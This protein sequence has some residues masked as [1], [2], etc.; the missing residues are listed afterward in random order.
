MFL[1]ALDV[2]GEHVTGIFATWIAKQITCEY[3]LWN[4][5]LD[6]HESKEIIHENT[7]YSIRGNEIHNQLA[8]G[9]KEYALNQSRLSR[10]LVTVRPTFPYFHERKNKMQIMTYFA[11]LSNYDTTLNVP[12]FPTNTISEYA[13]IKYIHQETMNFMGDYVIHVPYEL[14][15]FMRIINSF[16]EYWHGMRRPNFSLRYCRYCKYKQACYYYKRYYKERS[17]HE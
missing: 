17:K 6:F 4:Y 3:Q 12:D 15:R 8:F 14:P 7:P 9:T 16:K 1:Q 5:I 13:R 10:F 2:W 11:L